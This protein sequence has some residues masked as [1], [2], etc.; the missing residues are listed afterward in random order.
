MALPPGM[1]EEHAGI[2]FFTGPVEPAADPIG[3][4]TRHIAVVIERGADVVAEQLGFERAV[5]ALDQ[6]IGRIA[7]EPPEA[8]ALLAIVEL[9]QRVARPGDA[10]AVVVAGP[11]GD[12]AEDVVVEPG[13][14]GA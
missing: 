1:D 10:I 12:V 3:R 8:R 4:D 5:P 7:L 13:G 6:R 9:P 11:A 14:I 2:E